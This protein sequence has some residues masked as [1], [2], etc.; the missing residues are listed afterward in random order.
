[1]A[2]R[3]L[4]VYRKVGISDDYSVFGPQGFRCRRDPPPWSTRAE[5]RLRDVHPI[6]G[7][8]QCNRLPVISSKTIMPPCHMHVS[9]KCEPPS[10][11]IGRQSTV[12]I[13]VASHRLPQKSN[14][15]RQN[16]QTLRSRSACRKAPSSMLIWRWALSP[17][18]SILKIMFPELP[19]QGPHQH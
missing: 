10:S 1:M 15:P 19:I 9:A 13:L 7:A 11:K 18:G 5:P 2:V 8:C 12:N 6:S 3:C 16:I 17:E 14:H 4:L